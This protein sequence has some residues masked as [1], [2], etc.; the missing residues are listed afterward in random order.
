VSRISSFDQ[1]AK[2]FFRLTP[3]LL[4]CAPIQTLRAQEQPSAPLPQVNVTAAP[5]AQPGS[6]NLTIPS[7]AGSRLNLTPLETPASVSVLLGEQIRDLGDATINQAESRAVGVTAVPFTGNGNNSLSARGFYGPNSITQLYDGMQ[8]YNGGGV[9]A[10]PFDPWMVDRIEVLSGS[11]STLYGTGGIGGAFNVVPLQPDPTRQSETLQSSVGFFGT[12]HA[13]ADATGPINN[14]LSY[15]ADISG[16]TS[17]G[18]THPNGQSSSLAISGALRADFSPDFVVTLRDDYGHIQPS[19]YE[20]TP[21]L[22]G[23]VI[24]AFQSTNFNIADG[25]VNFDTNN[26][27]LKAVWTPSSGLSFTNDLYEITQERRYFEGMMYTF[28]PANDTVLRQDFRDIDGTQIQ[29]GD[30]GFATFNSTPWG[31]DNQTLLGF[32]VN[33]SNYDRY[34]NQSGT[35]TS[36]GKSTV[37]VYNFIPGTFTSTGATG[38][39]QQYD[40]GLQQVGG[41]TEDRL[42]LTDQLALLGGFRYDWY[43]TNLR[44]YPGGGQTPGIYNGTYTGPGYHIGVIYNPIPA[45][46]L[47][48]RYS[49]ATDPV[50]SL[51]SDSVADIAFGL[52]PAQQYEVG[53][54][55]SFFDNRLEATTALYEIVKHNLLTPSLQNSAIL[56]T[57]GQQSSHGIEGSLSYKL[58]DSLQLEANGTILKAQFDDYLASFNGGV[59]NLRGKL[60]QFV[61]ET[62]ANAT[63]HWYFLPDWELRGWLQYVG[64]RFSDNT[65]LY[66][67]PAYTVLGIGLRY[68]VNDHFNVD[69]RIDNLTDTTY[70]VSTYAGNST[71]LILGEPLSVTATLNAKF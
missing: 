16:Y 50:T 61:P 59:I 19:D 6:L 64:H 4:T 11:S 5:L 30:H 40:L 43:Y 60:P 21:T 62:A 28:N 42:R 10:F 41:F 37:S 25:Y 2:L 20:G 9:V 56:E 14:I 36:E 7:T 3:I 46:A 39:R 1:G 67:L 65:D 51:A 53:A 63:V 38:V 31:L 44:A 15:R 55:G 49:D 32:D 47:Y 27:H 68:T 22:G 13:A 34:D 58:T 24:G 23:N 54:K 8:L 48:A 45:S 71:Q 29:V 52:S 69:L 35:G 33:H 12:Y 66:R 17:D 26:V 57:V 70:A 18:W